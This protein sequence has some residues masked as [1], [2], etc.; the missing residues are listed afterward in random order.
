MPR[1]RKPPSEAGSKPNVTVPKE[2]LDQLAKGPIMQGGPES[3]FREFKKAMIER[4]MSA[5]MNE[6]CQGESK[7]DGEANQR[8]GTSGKTVITD[9]GAR[10]HRGTT[11]SRR[12]LRAA[13]HRQPRA[14]LHRRRS[15]GHCHVCPRHDDPGDPGLPCLD[16]RHGGFA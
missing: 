3:M 13:D 15:E 9:E 4:A 5:E 16:V 14:A 10:A 8:N 11:R 1:R 2:L 6:H 7:P 12:L